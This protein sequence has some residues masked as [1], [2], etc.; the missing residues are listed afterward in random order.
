VLG[1]E[2]QKQVLVAATSSRLASEYVEKGATIYSKGTITGAAGLLLGL[3]KE[4]DID[5][6]CLLGTT[7]SLS[8]DRGAGFSV[9]KFLINT[10]G[11]ERKER[12]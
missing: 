6:V 12:L 9:F 5:G 3:A 7:T 1:A 11:M 4:R 8:A 2:K 10:L